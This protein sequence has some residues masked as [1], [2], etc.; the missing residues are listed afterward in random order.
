MRPLFPW[1]PVRL[2]LLLV[3]LLFQSSALRAQGYGSVSGTIIDAQTK[4]PLGF[5]TIFIAQ[6]TYGTN[7]AENGTFK[8]PALPAGNHELVVSFLGY[9]T[10][11]HAFVL[12]AGQTQQFRFEL[13]PKANQLQEVVVGPDPHWKGNYEVFF[14]NFIGK[15]ALAA[16]VEIVNAD[17]L[18]FEYNAQQR[19][20]TAFA[21][22]ALVVQNNALGYRLH[23]LLKV[24]ELDMQKGLVFHA[25][26][27]RFEEM[28]PK[29][30]AQQ[31]KWEKAR[32]KAYQGSM[33]HF[34]RALYAK[35]LEK[36]GFN[37]RKLRRVPNPNRPA[38]E[39][40][41]AGIKRWRGKGPVVMQVGKNIPED[42]LQYWLRM[43]RLD[44][45]VAYL[46]KDPVPYDQIIRPDSATGQIRLQFTDFLS[47]VYEREGEEL[48]YANQNTFSKSKVPAK[49]QTSAITLLSPYTFLDPNGMIVNP[50]SHQVEGYWGFE[51][52]AEMLPLDYT[53]SLAKE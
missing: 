20:L 40:I 46:Y 42:S 34:G 2:G 30:K 45:Q 39:V 53:P 38:E 13:Q 19:N 51:K 35:T 7:A 50:Y 48:A 25:G 49:N 4:A 6:T 5:A 29:S 22:E 11:S 43:N 26:Y 17:V 3:F 18:H 10:V 24:F 9:E 21:D 14:R 1:F 16:Q 37:V 27:P 12:E 32:L 47:V 33:M 31:K 8:L 41:Q 15:S 36:E 28:K 44:K 52:M 23:F